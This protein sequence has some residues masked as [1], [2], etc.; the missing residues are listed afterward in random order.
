MKRRDFM[1]GAA[2]GTAV[3]VVTGT[4]LAQAQKAPAMMKKRIEIA[5]VTT[6][7]RDFLVSAPERN[8]SPSV[9]WT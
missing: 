8:A 5:I 7:P 6:W 2:A 4:G 1:T 3:A 9:F